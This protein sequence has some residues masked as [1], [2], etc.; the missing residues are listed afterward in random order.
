MAWA[1]ML[2][3][4]LH[5]EGTMATMF[6]DGIPS[7]TY[8]GNEPRVNSVCF[9]F[10]LPFFPLP[11]DCCSAGVELASAGSSSL[12]RPATFELLLP[13]LHA[14]TGGVVSPMMFRRDL[15]PPTA[16]RETYA[17]EVVGSSGNADFDREGAGRLTF[18]PGPGTEVGPRGAGF[19]EAVAEAQGVFREPWRNGVVLAEGPAVCKAGKRSCGCCGVGDGEADDDAAACATRSHT[20]REDWEEARIDVAFLALRTR[21]L[22]TPA[23]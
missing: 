4:Q 22:V 19:D 16:A 12:A 5:R 10:P 23:H 9:C 8:V 11:E 1:L 21:P 7:S 6:Y 18:A 2:S 13:L 3:T 17:L 15:L 14:A 20:C